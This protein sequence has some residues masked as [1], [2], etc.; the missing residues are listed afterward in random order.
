MT[1]NWALNEVIKSIYVC[2]RN[3]VDAMMDPIHPYTLYVLQSKKR[4]R[5]YSI[6]FLNDFRF[7]LFVSAV[8]R[9]DSL[10]I[11]SDG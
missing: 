4:G 10:Y 6:N 11:T 3:L 1:W 7:K 2:E 8:K 9:L 5:V